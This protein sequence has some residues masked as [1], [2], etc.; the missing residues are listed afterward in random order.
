ML[1]V[2]ITG[3][4]AAAI[5]WRIAERDAADQQA[6][7]ARAV[8]ASVESDADDLVV[9]TSGT[10][11][12]VGLDGTVSQASLERFATDLAA[13][14]VARPV[15]W[16]TPQAAD[17]GPE[18]PGPAWQVQ[19]AAIGPVADAQDGGSTEGLEPGT[20]LASG[21]A[22]AEAADRARSTG[23]PA[24]SRLVDAD[25]T[26]RLAVLKPVYR[27]LGPDQ[28]APSFVGV[29]ATTDLAGQLQ[30]HIGT[31][32]DGAVR[33]E[34]TDGDVVLAA[35]DTRPTG[36]VL[37]R[38]RLDDRDLEVRVQDDRPVN[39]DV[40]WF[41]L[42]IMAVIVAAAGVVGLRSARYDQE[43]RRTNAMIGRTAD[44]AQRLARAATAD[45]VAA[46]ISTHV[47]PLFEADIASFGE[48][49][50]DEDV[51]RLHHGPDVDPVLVSRISELRLADIPTLVDS[52]ESGRTV[53]LRDQADWER[54]LPDDVA[55]QLME[56]GARTAAVL[57]L[58]APGRGVVATV[59]IIWRRPLDFD[60]RTVG[61]LETVRE[62]CEQSLA[63]AVITDRVS[64]RA[65]RLA[66]LAE[67]LAGVDTVEATARTVTDLAVGAVGAS[68][69]SVGVC[70]DDL[71][72][73]RVHHGSTV[74]DRAQKAFSDLSLDSPLAFT[75]AAR[76]GRS[77]LCRDLA[78]YEARFPNTD[79]A[80]RGLGSGARAA[81]PLRADDRV[82]GSIVFAWDRPLE[83]D[84]DVLNELTTVAEMTA[85][86]VRRA[87]LIEAQAADARR[88]RALAQLAQG[89]AARSETADVA[90]FLVE[91][92]LAPLGAKYSV[93]GILDGD[94]LVRR[95]SA[96]LVETGLARL[97]QEYLTSA[98]DSP[99]PATDAV[100]TGETVFVG[101]REDAHAR[102]PE[103]S[104][105]WDSLEAHSGAAAPVR[106]RVGRVV[107][108]ISVLWD[109]PIVEHTDIRD[110]LDT[111][112]GMVGQ[113]LERTGLVDEL[114]R[115]VVRN[116]R[117]ADFARLLA[118][119]RS[120]DEMY[121]AVLDHA[122]A[123]VGAA[124]ADIALLTDDGRA[125]PLPDVGSS[126]PIIAAD[127]GREADL[128][129]TAS[130]SLRRR[131]MTTLGAGSFA[132]ELPADVAEG[133]SAAGVVSLVHLPLIAP[134]G[135]GLGVVALA[136]DRPQELTPT[137][138]A[139]MRTLAELVSQTLQR[140]QLREAEHRLVVSLQERVAHPLPPARGLRIAERYLPAAAQVGMGGDWFEGIGLDEHRVAIV[141]GDIAG[142]GINAV[143]DMVELRAIIGSLLRSSTPLEEV[144]PQVASL[145]QQGNSGLTATSCTAVFDTTA[146]TVRYVSAGHL[147]PVLARPD[148]TVEL[149]ELG[150]QP[151][152]GVPST[153][154]TPGTAP[155]EPGSVL[156]VYTD[157]IV[158]RRR[159]PIDESLE[160]LRG[161]MEELVSEPG[162][163]DVEAVADQLLERCLGSRSTDDDVALVVVAR[164]DET[165]SEPD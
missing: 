74:G 143:A 13:N 89:L 156:A 164:V 157:G 59:G 65:E 45:D 72:V 6:D 137:I 23:R 160:R 18:A 158:E 92:V 25:G 66:K 114:R 162:P 48:V 32:L 77:V 87:Q 90:G 64:E 163:R 67:R 84:D 11:T 101:N 122:A 49:D 124:V 14:G 78:E 147:P 146:D 131:A 20:V 15:A 2:L 58:E 100:R 126:P 88:S 63:R 29:V 107:A 129:D 80:N 52:L 47:P 154:V 41:L 22:L 104:A 165:L 24:I 120:V 26:A 94:E 149:L 31:D 60:E 28:T 55:R 36:G 54:E 144:Y 37:T 139:K 10:S 16:L 117:M 17:G 73:L 57:P 42:W 19:L 132:T 82:I 102:Y 98:L 33:F 119:V 116:Q 93:V 103:M 8:T 113:T 135:A 152:L 40:S 1:V 68:A 128:T 39:H 83:F 112:A 43:R 12:L 75:E 142:H 118:D 130:Q 95:Y 161:A 153:P 106:D 76:T 7:L 141:I 85:Q 105:A 79:D 115:S 81:L 159:E 148:G 4:L 91:S 108:V 30:R 44:L 51:V 127:R 138:L 121:R 38:M 110:A 155:F 133:L 9:A 50:D 134:D 151:L 111:V 123:P 56:A 136:W 5:T 21:T 99:T 61:T 70:D 53:L 150:R 145:L 96:G 35:S 3:S 86:A 125:A 109:R 27:I 62:L 97:G 71:G 46:V 140:T 34:I 69:A